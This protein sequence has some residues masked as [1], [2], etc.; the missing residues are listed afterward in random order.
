MK[1]FVI[2]DIHGKVHALEECLVKSGFDKE[3]DRLICLG[4]VCDRGAYVKESIDMLLE[5]K[6]LEYILGNHDIWFLEWA[7]DGKNDYYWI[8]FE[9]ADTIESY[10]GKKVPES[11]IELFDNAKLYLHEDKKIFVHAGLKPGVPL[12]QNTTED[13]V[14][15]RKLVKE[16]MAGFSNSRFKKLT[17]FDEVIVGHT[18]TQNYGSDKPLFTGEVRMLDTGAGWNHKL[19]IMN[20][21]TKEF[22]QSDKTTDRR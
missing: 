1:T 20:L 2:G 15:S 11:H 6:K 3:I 16:S 4:D 5:I 10:K 21:E 9:G 13:L 18:P 14:M 22:W 7:R 19:T 17:P 8:R 12:E